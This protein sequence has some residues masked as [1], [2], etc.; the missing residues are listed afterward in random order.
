MMYTL[1]S[2]PVYFYSIAPLVL[3]GI[4]AGVGALA[5]GIAG[6]AMN[7]AAQR[8]ANKTNIM[9][10]REQQAFEQ[11][12]VQQQ[13][14]YNSPVA[15]MQRYAQAGL[16]PNLVYSQGNPG[17]QSSI[18]SYQRADVKPALFNFQQNMADVINSVFG[19]MQ[20][21]AEIRKPNADARS[22]EIDNQ[23]KLGSWE[24][25]IQYDISR[26][27][28]LDEFYRNPDYFLNNKKIQNDLLNAQYNLTANNSALK[29]MEADWMNAGTIAPELYPLGDERRGIPNYEFVFKGNYDYKQALVNSTLANMALLPY[30]AES[31]RAGTSLKRSQ[32]NVQ[33]MLV[34]KMNE[35]IRKLSIMNKDPRYYY[36]HG[37]FLDQAGFTLLGGGMQS[38]G[39]QIDRFVDWLES[40]GE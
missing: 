12:M 2:D 26:Y 29:R 27:T 34:R 5:S 14:E 37:S 3:G 40:F 23:I 11:K 7:K 17:N 35:D 4:A 1:I 19:N 8:D 36:S 15:Q 38:L 33:N 9:L 10:A 21:V 24:N 31:L 39:K 28:A 6:G 20:A 30:K 18:P 22:T 25:Q 13:N 16:N 32:I